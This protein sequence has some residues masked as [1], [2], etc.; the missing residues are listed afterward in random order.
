MIMN[1]QNCMLGL[2]ITNSVYMLWFN[3]NDSVYTKYRNI[4]CSIRHSFTRKNK[5][6]FYWNYANFA[7][8]RG[9]KMHDVV[10]DD[11]MSNVIVLQYQYNSDMSLTSTNNN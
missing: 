2:D 4:K 1:K 10:E 7:T 6:T 3:E 5:L 11:K 9:R 8:Q